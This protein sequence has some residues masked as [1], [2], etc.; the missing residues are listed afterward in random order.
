MSDWRIEIYRDGHF[1]PF[2]DIGLIAA[3]D[4]RAAFLQAMVWWARNR[5]RQAV[6]LRAVPA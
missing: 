4:G 6:Q 2:D 3:S 1:E 5:G